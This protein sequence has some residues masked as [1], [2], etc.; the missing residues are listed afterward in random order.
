LVIYFRGIRFAYTPY[1]NAAQEVAV[2]DAVL[3]AAAALL[4]VLLRS[5]YT[6]KCT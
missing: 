3:L 6:H 5:T 4:V 1:L 2:L